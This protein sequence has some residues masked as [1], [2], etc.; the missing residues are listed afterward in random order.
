MH[1]LNNKTQGVASTIAR[2]SKGMNSNAQEHL[3][4]EVLLNSQQ[5]KGKHTVSTHTLSQS[6]E[7]SEIDGTSGQ[8]LRI[9]SSYTRD[10][11]IDDQV[12]AR[13]SQIMSN[14]VLNIS[15]AHKIYCPLNEYRVTDLVRRPHSLVRAF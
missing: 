11:V 4:G 7:V 13:Q 6:M 1:L 12:P 15:Q 9:P 5:T 2:S 14:D 3:G 10:E 8:P